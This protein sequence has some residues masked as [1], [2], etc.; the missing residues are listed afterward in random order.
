M[1]DPDA[2]YEALGNRLLQFDR[3]TLAQL[4]LAGRQDLSPEKTECILN[5][6]EGAGDRFLNQSQEK[7]D[8]NLLE[9]ILSQRQ[10]VHRNDTET[11]SL[12]P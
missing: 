6:L 9:E 1:A 3:N 4:L 11:G 5:D 2:I 10:E 8:R 12:T 7:L